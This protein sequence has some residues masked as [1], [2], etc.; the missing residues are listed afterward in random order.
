MFC[1]HHADADRIALLVDRLLDV[2]PGARP[3]RPRADARL[4]AQILTQMTSRDIVQH[5]TPWFVVTGSRRRCY[6]LQ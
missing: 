1:A 5:A 6:G 3:D 2:R 4:P